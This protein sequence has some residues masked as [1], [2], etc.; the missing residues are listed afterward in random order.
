L[1]F[2]SSTVSRARSST[3][4]RLFFFTRCSGI[5]LSFVSVKGT[6]PLDMHEDWRYQ[7]CSWSP[8]IVAEFAFWHTSDVFQIDGSLQNLSS[9]WS[10]SASLQCDLAEIYLIKLR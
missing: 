8:C 3:S 10:F 2:S 6:Q 7:R 5:F 4:S 1:I 9:F